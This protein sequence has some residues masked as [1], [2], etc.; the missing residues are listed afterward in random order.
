[1][2]I[3]L[4]GAELFHADRQGKANTNVRKFAN[5]AKNMSKQ[6]WSI[7]PNV[8]C[9]LSFVTL[10]IYNLCGKIPGSKVTL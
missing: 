10:A 6:Y 8:M 4:V 1:M 7:I 9:I 5:I 2:K 3:C